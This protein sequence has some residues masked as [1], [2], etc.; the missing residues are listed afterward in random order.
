MNSQGDLMGIC[1]KIRLMITQ[2]GLAVEPGNRVTGDRV[3]AHQLYW[4]TGR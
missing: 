2:V 4:V 3:A 1:Q